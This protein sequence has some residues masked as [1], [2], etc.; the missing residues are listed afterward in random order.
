VYDYAVPVPLLTLLW[1][2]ALS[3]LGVCAPL[4]LSGWHPLHGEPWQLCASG[5]SYFGPL[6]T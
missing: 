6:D 2:V 1:L 5:C 3:A 4:L